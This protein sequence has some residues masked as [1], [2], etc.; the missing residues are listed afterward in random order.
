MDISIDTATI[1][2][3]FARRDEDLRGPDFFDVKNFPAMTYRGRGIRATADGAWLM[4]GSLTI[5]GV[6]KE[7]PLTFTFKG[8]FP[9]KAAK[10]P[11][12]AAFHATAAVKRGD[13]GM[14]RDNLMELGT[15]PL[16][17]DVEIQIDVEAN[18]RRRHNDLLGLG[19]IRRS[20][21]ISCLSPISDT[22]SKP[23]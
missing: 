19:Q 12:R 16:G 1:N 9:D 20:S 4:D 10:N 17:T 23:L 21:R 8:M 13:F 6:T 11:P 22:I 18:A 3:Q 7:V 14:T 2:T 5:R 15:N